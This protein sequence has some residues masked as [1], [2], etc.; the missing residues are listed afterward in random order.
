MEETGE[1]GESRVLKRTKEGGRGD[2]DEGGRKEGGHFV[3]EFQSLKG[4]KREGQWL[5]CIWKGH[6]LPDSAE[7]CTGQSSE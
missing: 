6:L 5:C 4:R 2:E 1:D 7:S 3:G